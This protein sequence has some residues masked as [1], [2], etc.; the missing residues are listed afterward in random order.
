MGLS[1]GGINLFKK[2]K[3]TEVNL[4]YMNNSN[5]QEETLDEMMKRK[6]NAEREKRI[7]ENNKKKNDS[8]DL[9]NET[10]IQMTNKNK[11][12][13]EQEEKK[14]NDRNTRKRQKKIKRIKRILGIITFTTLIG[15]TIIFALTSPIFNIKSI[16]VIGNSKISSESIISLSELKQNQN[17]FKISKNNSV[18]KIKEN[19]YIQ[20]ASI[21]AKYPDKIQIKVEERREE[22]TILIGERKA[23]INS[24]GYILDIREDVSELPAIVGIKEDKEY[25]VG[26]RLEKDNLEK[27]EE[28]I[29]L[30]TAM[31][32]SNLET[33]NITIDITQKNDYIVTM[34]TEKKN[35]HFGNT[36]NLSNKMLYVL[37][38]LD[39][40]KEKE[41]DIFVNGDLNGK[42]RPYF[43][44]KV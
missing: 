7:K 20:S 15:G 3:E 2:S 36:Q 24:Q 38:I 21:I 32:E 43:R 30:K 31:D 25:V 6:K 29:R 18:E 1:E 13:K 26:E 16:E 37:A 23:Y 41:G 33:K 17:I 34:P 8:F 35:I 9:D 22:Y 12:K 39:K 5:N 44:E 11:L 14:K 19:P 42:F 28:I 10:V 40:E 27:M 4:Y